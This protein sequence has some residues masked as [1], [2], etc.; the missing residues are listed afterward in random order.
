MYTENNL[1]S[2]QYQLAYNP[3]YSRIICQPVKYLLTSNN[4]EFLTQSQK[5]HSGHS[6]RKIVTSEPARIDRP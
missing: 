5:S 6:L 4:Y 1:A 3:T 2:R